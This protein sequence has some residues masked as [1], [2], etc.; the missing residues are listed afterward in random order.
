MTKILVIEDDREINQLV[1]K[2]L[3]KEGFEIHSVYDGKEALSYITN[4]E[5]GLVILDLMLPQIE[6]LELLR[7]IRAKGTIPVMILSAKDSELDKI[8]GLELGADDYMTKPFTI[9]SLLRG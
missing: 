1:T 3:E 8:R 5:Y 7:K 9:G 2:Y 6:G 4:H